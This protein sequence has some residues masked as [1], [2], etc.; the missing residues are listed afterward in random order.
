MNIN[1]HLKA[2]FCYLVQNIY[3]VMYI[4]VKYKFI[5]IFVWQPLIQNKL[6][7]IHPLHVN[8]IINLYDI[9]YMHTGCAITRP[10]KSAEFVLTGVWTV[11]SPV[12]T[13][14]PSLYWRVFGLVCIQRISHK[15]IIIFTCRANICY[16]YHNIGCHPNTTINFT[17]TKIYI[18]KYIFCTKKH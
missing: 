10:H 9:L 3:Y 13:K 5:F 16:L 1:L 12:H 7:K 8:I 4:Y 18:I 14:V 15:F 11:R 6:T 2:D 17:F